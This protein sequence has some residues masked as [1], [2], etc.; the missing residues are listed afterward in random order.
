M[1]FISFVIPVFN[2]ATC[3]PELFLSLRPLQQVDCEI[4]FVEDCS[5]D[6]SLALLTDLVASSNLPARILRHE[7]NRGISAARNSGLADATGKYVWFVDSDDM[8]N[9]AVLPRI[10]ETLETHSPDVLCF[11]YLEVRKRTIVELDASGVPQRTK[12]F[13]PKRMARRALKANRLLE[14]DDVLTAKFIRDC[15]FYAWSY[16]FARALLPANPFPEGSTFE[17]VAS[18]AAL[19]H[20]ANSFYYLRV[21]AIL[22]RRHRASITRNHTVQNVINLGRSPGMLRQR[23]LGSSRPL[24]PRIHHAIHALWLQTLVWGTG[25][26]VR[27]GHLPAHGAELAAAYR[28]YRKV[29]GV[30]DLRSLKR[31]VAT[32]PPTFLLALCIA[33]LPAGI[34]VHAVGRVHG[35]YTWISRA[36]GGD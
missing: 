13:F 25:H 8:L 6:D 31:A 28:E 2:V 10:L 17:D 33:L 30:L 26:M 11:D 22:Y 32:P 27:S 29:G 18:I 23:L 7:R 24:T 14:V 3:L 34:A 5:T 21:E 36:R 15:R 16:C 9:G 35:L 20:D 12:G 19:V 4:V 1:P